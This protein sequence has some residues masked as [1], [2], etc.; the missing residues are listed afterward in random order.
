MQILLATF[1]CFAIF[2]E[3]VYDAWI[4]GIQE[5]SDLFQAALPPPAQ[6][7]AHRQA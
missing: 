5:A 4:P 7:L 1:Y 3:G 2:Q 6:L